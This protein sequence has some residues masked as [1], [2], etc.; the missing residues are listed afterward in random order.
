ME[1]ESIEDKQEDFKTWSRS[2]RRS[3]NLQKLHGV[4]TKRRSFLIEIQKL[5]SSHQ[6]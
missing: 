2:A 1:P 6:N 3:K 5:D 4:G